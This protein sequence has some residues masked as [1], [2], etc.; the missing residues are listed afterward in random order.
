MSYDLK[1]LR[2]DLDVKNV[3]R[4]ALYIGDGKWGGS[5]WNFL[6]NGTLAFDGTREELAAFFTALGP[7]LPCAECRKHYE[8]Y[9]AKEGAPKT[10]FTAFLWLQKLEQAVGRQKQKKVPRRIKQIR[11]KSTNPRI[12]TLNTRPAQNKAA[13]KVT[14]R[15][16]ILSRLDTRHC[17][18]CSKSRA[19][20]GVTAASMGIQGI[21]KPATLLARPSLPTGNIARR[22]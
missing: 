11:K 3:R 5:A 14:K 15:E 20:L 8:S 2:R 12:Q 7:L 4:P 19:E 6:Y 21:G 9:L 13:P 17:P 16:D 10:P 18:N 22:I 1:Q